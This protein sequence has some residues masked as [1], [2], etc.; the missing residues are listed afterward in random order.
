MISG[1]WGAVK[2]KK[3]EKKKKKQLQRQRG[4]WF[5]G[6]T[7]AVQDGLGGLIRKGIWYGNPGLAHLQ[8]LL[9]LLA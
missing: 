7:K 5:K 4:K 1:D 8:F 3:K 6:L 2:G 9:Y